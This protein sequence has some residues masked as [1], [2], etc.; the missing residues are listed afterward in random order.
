MFTLGTLSLMIVLVACKREDS[1]NIAQDRIYSDYQV[2]YDAGKTQTMASATFRA[3]HSTG[4]KVELTYPAKIKFRDENMSWKNVAGNYQT[5]INGNAMNNYFTY[6]DLDENSFENQALDISFIDLPYG[7]TAISKSGNFFLPWNGD[8]V[9]NGETV[10]VIIKSK[11]G[12]SE[13]HWTV[14]TVNSTHITLDAYTLSQ[15][16]N[17]NADIWIERSKSESLT[18]VPDAGGRITGTWKSNV[19]IIQITN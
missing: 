14:S 6:V 8:I 11:E 13:K 4:T 9:R 12:G 7:I 3:D 15:L 2:V 16:P 5:T 17:G 18:M 1:Q 10:K 19:Q